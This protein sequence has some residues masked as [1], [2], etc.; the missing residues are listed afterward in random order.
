M[1]SPWKMLPLLSSPRHPWAFTMPGSGGLARLLA[2]SAGDHPFHM[3]E[4]QFA[5]GS[6]QHCWASTQCLAKWEW[7]ITPLEQTS[8]IPWPFIKSWREKV[9]ILK[10][11][12][13]RIMSPPRASVSPL[14]VRCKY[15]T[16]EHCMDGTV[17]KCTALSSPQVTNTSLHLLLCL[18]SALIEIQEEVKGR[19]HC[20]QTFPP[21][22][23]SLGVTKSNSLLL[24]ATVPDSEAVFAWMM[25]PL[26]TGRENGWGRTTFLYS[27]QLKFPFANTKNDTFYQCQN[28]ILKY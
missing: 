2:R 11:S 4:Q 5:G 26:T 27:P 6:E 12:Y 19:T 18:P 21:S 13:R 3:P 28:I 8:F 16:P 20:T 17:T 10:S 9:K 15:F 25:M 1:A 7:E 22:L 14:C 23:Q 24:T